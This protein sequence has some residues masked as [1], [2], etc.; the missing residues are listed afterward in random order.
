MPTYAPDS[1]VHRLV[2]HS[3]AFLGCTNSKLQGAAMR[4]CA[5]CKTLY[6]CLDEALCADAGDLKGRDC[7]RVDWARHKAW[8]KTQAERLERQAENSGGLAEDFEAW[9][10]CIYDIPATIRSETFHSV[11]PGLAVFNHP[12][13]IRTKFVVL[14]LR[15]RI[16][17]AST[18]RKMFEY[19]HIETFDRSALRLALG[20]DAATTQELV[21][22]FSEANDREKSRGKAGVALL[23]IKV[24][25]PEG[26][27]ITLA[28]AMPVVLRMDE[29]NQ[30]ETPGWRDAIKDI[31]NKGT[32]IKHRIAMKEKAGEL[33]VFD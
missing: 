14:S 2:E 7:Q 17:S 12:D 23:I 33:R 8:C 19:V 21:D 24:L 22:Q 25:S 26:E 27:H 10:E 30:S 13:N 20:G 29:L 32:S 1:M 4:L 9:Y 6:Y 3:C 5:Q 18:Q 15:K 28:R 11:A 31:I 16:E